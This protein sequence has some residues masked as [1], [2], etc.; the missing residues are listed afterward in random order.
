MYTKKVFRAKDMLKWTRF[1]TLFFFIF[2]MIIVGLYYFF[3]ITWFK[4]PWTPLAL[5]GTAVS[6]VIGFQNNSAYGRIWEARKIWGGIVNTSR[7]FGMFV[8]DMVDTKHS[9]SKSSEEDIQNDIKTLTYR[10]IAWMTALRHSM[11]TRKSWETVLDEKSNKEWTQIVAPPEWNSTLENDLKPY[12][13]KEDLAYTL[14]KNNKQTALL[15]LQSHHLKNLKDQGKIWEFS[16]L[17]LENVLEELFTLQGKSERIKNFPYP[18]HFA[19]LNHYFMWLFVLLLPIALVPQFSEIGEEISKTLPS[20]GKLFMWLSVPFY[21]I[22]AWIFHTMERIGRTGENPFEGSANDVPI[23]T[24][25]RGIEID[26]RQNLG[27]KDDEIPNQFPII[28]NTQM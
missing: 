6:F 14:S 22:V 23:S 3:N 21:V 9:K 8:Q 1:E 5:I 19:T 11:R 18:R 28:H 15:Y 12:L 13:N 26:L 27:E 7:T 17:E 2:I 16:F 24:I 20:I 10:H 4:I 25:A